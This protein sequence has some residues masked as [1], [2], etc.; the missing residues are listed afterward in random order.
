MALMAMNTRLEDRGQHGW[1]LRLNCQYG[2]AIKMKGMLRIGWI[3]TVRDAA[4]QDPTQEEYADEFLEQV[5]RP[6]VTSLA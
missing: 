3:P 6:K 4:I 1:C 5:C 2:K